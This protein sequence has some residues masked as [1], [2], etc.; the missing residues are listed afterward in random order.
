[1][2]IFKINKITTR[3]DTLVEMTENPRNF[4]LKQTQTP[5]FWYKRIYEPKQL[6]HERRK[7]NCDAIGDTV[8][9]RKLA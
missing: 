3:P 2:K 7:S 4:Q 1:M 6:I 9:P 5:I 8:N